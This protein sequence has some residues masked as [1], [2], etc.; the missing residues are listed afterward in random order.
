[1]KYIKEGTEFLDQLK[2]KV[3]EQQWEI[4]RLNNIINEIAEEILKELEENH[5][6]SYGVALSIRQKL[7]DYK[8][9]KGVDK[10]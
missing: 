2:D 7:L 10:E 5:H 9:I 4:K 1:V 3:H 8:E 6:L